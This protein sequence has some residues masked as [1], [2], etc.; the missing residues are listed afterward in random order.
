MMAHLWA[1]VWAQG[2]RRLF[3]LVKGLTLPGIRFIGNRYR[4]QSG[5]YRIR[6]DGVNYDNVE[7]WREATR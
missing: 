3:T 4:A 6:W 5:R 1:Q 7:A 2:P